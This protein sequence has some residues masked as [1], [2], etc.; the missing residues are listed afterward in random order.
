MTSIDSLVQ[1]FQKWLNC[2]RMDTKQVWSREGMFVQLLLLEQPETR[3]FPLYLI[4][5]SLLIR[6]SIFFEIHDQ[7]IHPARFNH[8]MVN[9]D[10]LP[11]LL[12]G[13]M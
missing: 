1:L 8:D 4:Y 7:R 12:D 3:N 11:L 2:L 10:L 6:Q 5:L 13:L 9:L